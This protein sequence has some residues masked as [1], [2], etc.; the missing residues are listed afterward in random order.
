M[1]SSFVHCGRP[2]CLVRHVPTKRPAISSGSINQHPE[3]IRLQDWLRIGGS[4]QAG[5]G[6]SGCFMCSQD[7]HHACIWMLGALSMK[8]HGRTLVDVRFEPILWKNT[9]LLAQKVLSNSSREHLFYQAFCICCG[10]GRILASLRRFW[11]VAA[12][13]NSSFAPFGPRNRSLPNPRIRLRWAK[14]ISTFFLS[15]IEMAY[16]LVLAMSRAT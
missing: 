5:K 9:V 6:F 3:S 1:P 16:C 8:R 10:A 13:K 15:R 12:S 11:A 7:R 2:A 4:E 14:S